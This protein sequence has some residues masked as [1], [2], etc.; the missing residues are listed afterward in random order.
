MAAAEVG[1]VRVAAFSPR[2]ERNI[3]IALMSVDVEGSDAP[4]SV[5]SEGGE[6]SASLTDLP[7]IRK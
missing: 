4:L 6:R 3:G 2:L 5:A 7:F 1:S